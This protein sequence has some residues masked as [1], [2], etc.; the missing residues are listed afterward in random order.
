MDDTDDIEVEIVEPEEIEEDETSESV[1]KGIGIVPVIILSVLAALFGALGGAYGAQYITKAPDLLTVDSQIALKTAE[2]KDNHQ[3]ALNKLNE[4]I[5]A[6]KNDLMQVQGGQ[7]SEEVLAVLQNRVETLESR[8]LPEFPEIDKDV[9][10]ALQKAQA[11]GFDW[12]DM[13][14]IETRL[15]KLE[16]DFS[17]VSNR[18]IRV[19][20]SVE[21]LNNQ[22][23]LDMPTVKS[24]VPF[25]I[26]TNVSLPAFPET[27]LREAAALAVSKKGFFA[28]TLTKHIDVRHPSDPIVLIE[29]ASA[30]VKSGDLELARKTLDALPDDIK[31]VGQ[32]WRDAASKF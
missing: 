27:A 12:P 20:D 14:G 32:D 19:S 24:D 26:E 3:K 2:L 23:L 31:S 4:D 15:D 25:S 7:A 30:A 28:R 29:K 18:L 5:S 16:I 6:L 11:D 22:A 1:R 9:V 10:T 8:P 21:G 17:D 13:S